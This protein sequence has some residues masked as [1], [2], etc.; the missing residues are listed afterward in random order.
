MIMGQ[1]TGTSARFVTVLY[2]CAKARSIEASLKG[3]RLIVKHDGGR[4]I[5]QL[6]EDGTRP[7]L[8]K[9]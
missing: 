3:S 6:K 9:R 5:I 4:D 1:Q 7:E 8:V 2:P